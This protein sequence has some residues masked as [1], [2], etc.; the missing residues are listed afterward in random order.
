MGFEPTYDGFANRCLTTW[1]PHRACLSVGAPL[2]TIACFA[3][4]P[5]LLSPRPPATPRTQ[6][7][8][9][10]E[11][12]HH[13]TTGARPPSSK[14]ARLARRTRPATPG[15]RLALAWSLDASP[16][17]PAP[18]SALRHRDRR[19]L[20]VAF[21]RRADDLEPDG[22][23]LSLAPGLAR[24]HVARHRPRRDVALL[25]VRAGARARALARGAA[26]RAR[27][28]QHHAVSLRRR[29][30]HRARA[31]ER[32]GGVSHR[33]RRPDHEHRARR[34]SARAGV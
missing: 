10:E 21:H 12:R 17:R 25:R 5:R 20:L 14:P 22:R 32:Q 34:H 8:A 9:T 28:E 2:Q 15:T 26:L 4:G 30:E 24:R 1:L 31:V 29:L 23:V 6:A 19:R 16:H 13:A 7:R 18:R 11:A 3:P 27:G 33:G